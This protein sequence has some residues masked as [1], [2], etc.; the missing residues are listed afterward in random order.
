MTAIEH[1]IN[2]N[3]TETSVGLFAMPADNPGLM[4][5]QVTALSGRIP[6]LYFIVFVNTAAVAWT[7][8]GIAPDVLTIGFPTIIAAAGLARARAWLNLRRKAISDADARTLLN[9]TVI[10]ASAFGAMFLA[11]GLALY[12]YGDA[13]AQ[14]HVVFYMVITVIGGIFCLMHLRSAALLLTGVTVIPFSIFFLAT[15]RPVF[16]AIAINT[17][18]V[19]AVM[20]YVLL[21]YSRDFANMVAYQQKLIGTHEA[22]TERVRL[23]AEIER[24]AQREIL[25]HAGRFEVALNNMLQGLCMFDVDDRLIVCNQHYAKMYA[26]PHELTQPGAI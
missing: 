9:A 23:A 6:L 3:T 17:L 10:V 26:L 19:S 11:W 18:L 12:Q 5:S 1:P 22:E 4:Q 24:T 13:Y 2:I 7:H 14:G 21:T 15:G 16:I 25:K 8:Y 20:V